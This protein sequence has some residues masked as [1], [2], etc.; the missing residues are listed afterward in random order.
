MVRDI[1]GKKCRVIVFKAV[2]GAIAW[3]CI[4]LSTFVQPCNI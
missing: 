4:S 2:G 3:D 1:F